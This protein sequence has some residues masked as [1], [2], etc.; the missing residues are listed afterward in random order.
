MKRWWVEPS[1]R[2]SR[3][4][5][6]IPEDRRRGARAWLMR[7]LRAHKPERGNEAGGRARAARRARLGPGPREISHGLDMATAPRL[8]ESEMPDAWRS[9]RD[10]LALPPAPKTRARLRA[11]AVRQSGPR[12]APFR[13]RVHHGAR[14]VLGGPAC[15]NAWRSTASR[16]CRRGSPRNCW[17]AKRRRARR[18]PSSTAR[19]CAREAAP[20]APKTPC[21]TGKSAAPETSA[22]ETSVDAATLLEVARGRTRRD[23]DWALRQL[24]ES[25]LAGETGHRFLQPLKLPIAV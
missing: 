13:A 18:W 8:I 9:G 25:A 16:I 17:R 11:G 19:C 4:A 15:S 6:P 5:S 23:A 12:G 1:S 21:E 7:W 14:D 24:A 20:A 2:S 22:S 10:F 3:R